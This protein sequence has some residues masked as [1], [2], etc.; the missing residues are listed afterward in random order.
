MAIRS[1]VLFI[2]LFIF[3]IMNVFLSVAFILTNCLRYVIV[4]V[5]SYG[6]LFRCGKYS[7]RCSDIN[8]GNVTI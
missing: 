3:M 8:C 4:G 1:R 2:S 7:V 5:G 6:L